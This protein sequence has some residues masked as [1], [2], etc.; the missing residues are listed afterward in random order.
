MTIN[1]GLRRESAL[2]LFKGVLIC[3]MIVT[4]GVS[5]G[6]ALAGGDK[7]LLR[8]EEARRATQVAQRAAQEAARQAAEELRLQ[9]QRDK[10]LQEQRNQLA[11]PTEAETPRHN[12]NLGPDTFDRSWHLPGGGRVTKG[13]N[14]GGVSR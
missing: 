8:Q 4:S 6:V 9:Q 13:N 2:G 12:Y 7:D 10:S 11:R 5:G 3:L 1:C 14:V